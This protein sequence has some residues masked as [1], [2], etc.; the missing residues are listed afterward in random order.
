VQR[1]AIGRDAGSRI[2]AKSISFGGFFGVRLA[3]QS[4]RILRGMCG[5]AMQ[6][7]TSLVCPTQIA[8]IAARLKTDTATY[9]VASSSIFNG[10]A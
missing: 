1:S 5:N 7:I 4:R 8:E 3:Q 6:I 2:F 9:A 10:Q